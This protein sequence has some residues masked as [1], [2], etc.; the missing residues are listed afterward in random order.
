MCGTRG[1]SRF[2]S[3]RFVRWLT[4][5]SSIPLRCNARKSARSLALHRR[6][7]FTVVLSPR[8]APV[9]GL[10]GEP[11]SAWARRILSVL[12]IRGRLVVNS[13]SSKAVHGVVAV[14]EFLIRW[15]VGPLIRATARASATIAAP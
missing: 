7:S 3:G 5:W 13:K 4:A 1:G 9:D 14:D 10:E 8:L 11:K 2:R 15:P 12:A 6:R